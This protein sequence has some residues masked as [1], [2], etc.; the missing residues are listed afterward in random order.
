M[1]WEDTMDHRESVDYEKELLRI[2]EPMDSS[3]DESEWLWDA[4]RS[5]VF[6]AEHYA[7]AWGETRPQELLNIDFPAVTEALSRFRR[8]AWGVARF[9]KRMK[10]VIAEESWPSSSFETIQRELRSVGVRVNSANPR[11]TRVAAVF[12]LWMST[13]RPISIRI[14]APSKNHP[15]A[16]L[17]FCSAFTFDLTQHYLSLFGE[18]ALGVDEGDIAIRKSHI[19]HDLF[20]RQLALSPLEM[21]YAGIF[22][23]DPKAIVAVK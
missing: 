11:K 17:T 16:L 1:F 5:L 22:R 21:L 19:I 14:E 3:I 4:A 9:E 6:F 13:F 8:D 15:D 18:I 10:G 23:P 7:M 12:A 20:C 2:F